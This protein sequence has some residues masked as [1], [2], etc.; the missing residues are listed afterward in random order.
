V[1]CNHL[2]SSRLSVLANRWRAELN[3]SHCDVIYCDMAYCYV[4]ID[5]SCDVGIIWSE[6]T[7]SC[8]MEEKGRRGERKGGEG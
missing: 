4:M 2:Q 8:G 1:E 5:E 3:G 7:Q 6:G